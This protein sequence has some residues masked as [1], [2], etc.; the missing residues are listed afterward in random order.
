MIRY[1]QNF[2]GGN[3]RILIC[4]EISDFND[5]PLISLDFARSTHI[6]FSLGMKSEL[7]RADC[8]LTLQKTNRRSNSFLLRYSN[9]LHSK[10]ICSHC[11]LCDDVFVYVGVVVFRI[12]VF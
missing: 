5:F 11:D 8:P 7:H 6:D 3:L 2:I 4:R 12:H 9:V 10:S 1:P